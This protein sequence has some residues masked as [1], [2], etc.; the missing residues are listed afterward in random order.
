MEIYHYIKMNEIVNKFLLAGDKFMPEMHLRDPKVGTYSACGPFTKTKERVKKFKETGD[1]T[2]IYK[3]QLDQACFQH[4]LAY[5]NKDLATRTNA[6]KVL[7]DKAFQI[8]QDTNIDGYQ[9]S[10]ASMVYKFFNKKVSGAGDKT[11]I[12]TQL[13]DEL[14]RKII[15]KFPKRKVIPGSFDNIWGADLADVQLISKYNK[16]FRFLL[17]VIDLYSKYA[18][19]VPIKDKKGTT[20]TNAFK[21]ILKTSG[22]KPNKIWVDKGSEFYN[23]NFKSFLNDNNIEMYSTENEGKSVVAERFIRTLK[24]KIYKYMTS[25]SKNTYIDNLQNIVDKYNNSYHR[26]IKMKPV[27]VTKDIDINYGDNNFNKNNAKFK[28]GDHVRISKY[29]NIFKKGYMPN[30]TEE[31]FVV[32]EVKN[33]VPWTYVIQDLNGDEV[34]GTFYEQELQKTDQN[35]FRVEKVIK[36]K[37]DKLFVK[38][39]GYSDKFNSWIDKK[40]INYKI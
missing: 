38:W 35:V 20:I 15:R 17:C 1:V 2:N 30:W 23:H 21:T 34:K 19:V 6:D 10:L 13:A 29:K 16:G 18:W 12:N 9:R 39:K 4:D 37:G 33:T 32:K 11:V 31:I 7:R 26:T 5:G 3:N 40:D 27:D 22:R 8:A 25:I 24:T 14:H 36:R 28:L